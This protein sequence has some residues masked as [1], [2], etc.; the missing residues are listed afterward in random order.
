MKNKVFLIGRLTKDI[1]LEKYN[2]TSVATFGL[3]IN[4]G[5]DKNGNERPADFINLKA[6]NK[7]AEVMKQYLSKGRKIAVEAHLKSNT[8]EDKDGNKK[9][10]L[11]VI[12]DSFEFCD[13]KE[14]T[15]ENANTQE[16]QKSDPFKEFA[17]EHQNS[18]DDLPF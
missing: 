13:S 1:E 15:K 14:E 6:F 9:Y 3:A 8:Y 5:K 12:V 18:D 4:N 2:D 7:N 11:N 16:S 17:V 10:S